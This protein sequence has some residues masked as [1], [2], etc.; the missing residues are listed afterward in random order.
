MYEIII[1]HFTF[2][3]AFTMASA[4][5]RALKIGDKAPAFSGRDQDGKPVSLNSHQAL[6]N[7]LIS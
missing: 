3:F 6:F 2:V 7:L 5:T 4:Q 1:T